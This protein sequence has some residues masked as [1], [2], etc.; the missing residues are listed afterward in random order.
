MEFLHR[1]DRGTE[2]SDGV[3]CP[4]DADF[5]FSRSKIRFAVCRCFF[6]AFWSA[7]RIS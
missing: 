7:S 2:M 6:G 4:E 3:V 5:A 1:V